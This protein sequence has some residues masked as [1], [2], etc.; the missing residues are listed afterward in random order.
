[1]NFQPMP[2]DNLAPTQPAPQL[3]DQ[4]ALTIGA[5]AGVCFALAII[6]A[7]AVILVRSPEAPRNAEQAW[8][9]T[10]TVAPTN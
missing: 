7:A 9:P 6:S 3:D 8:A 4:K 2:N 5:C 1:M 10:V